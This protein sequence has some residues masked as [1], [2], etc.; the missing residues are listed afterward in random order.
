MRLYIVAVVDSLYSC[1]IFLLCVWCGNNLR[2]WF[3]FFLRPGTNDILK[4]TRPGKPLYYSIERES[5]C[6]DFENSCLANR[7]DSSSTPHPTGV[8]RH[9][10]EKRAKMIRS[11]VYPNQSDV[12]WYDYLEWV[13][14]G[15][16][17]NGS[18]K[19]RKIYKY[20]QIATNL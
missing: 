2:K 9:E 7:W 8:R 13:S 6:M 5:F 14:E 12:D 1:N 18:K 17:M 3:V 19:N 16:E 4:I 11:Q 20:G 15:V 10:N